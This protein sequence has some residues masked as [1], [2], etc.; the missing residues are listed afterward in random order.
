MDTLIQTLASGLALGATYALVALGF[1]IVFRS[2]GVVN[3]AQGALV[4]VGAYLISALTVSAG[5]P[6]IASVAIVLVAVAALAALVDLTVLRRLSAK[7]ANAAVI[8]TLALGIGLEAVAEIFF[9]TVQRPLGDPWGSSVVSFGGASIPESQIW[10]IVIAAVVAG[11]FLYLDRGTL[12]GK[13]MRAAAHDEEAALSVGIPTWQI[14]TFAWGIAGVLAVI[15]AIFLT[16]FPSSVTPAVSWAALAAFPAL[17]LGG[18]D[19]PT[20]ALIGGVVIGVVQVFAGTYQPAWLGPGAHAMV[21]YLILIIILLVWPYGL[22]GS[23]PKER[24]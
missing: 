5:L 7:Q 17:V 14:R 16:S 8:I 23:R 21:P 6:F 9:G 13:A 1:S 2:T 22:F 11:L 3:F 4:L 10:A 12:L 24:L 15:A 18:L 20:G 19:A